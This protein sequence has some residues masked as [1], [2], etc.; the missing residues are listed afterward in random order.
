MPRG[1]LKKLS[2]CI[3]TIDHITISNVSLTAADFKEMKTAVESL[4][5]LTLTNNKLKEI[6]L[7]GFINL[8]TLLLPNNEL[9][10]ILGL[11]KCP[12]LTTLDLSHNK[13][14]SFSAIGGIEYFPE[15]CKVSIDKNPLPKLV[16]DALTSKGIVPVLKGI[17]QLVNALPPSSTR[18]KNKKKT[19]P[20]IETQPELVLNGH[21]HS[22]NGAIFSVDGGKVYTVSGHVCD[23]GQDYT[24]RIWDRATGAQ[25]R[26]FNDHQ[27]EVVRVAAH[28]DGK[29]VAT[30]GLDGNVFV[31][32]VN[33]GSKVETYQGTEGVCF[34]KNGEMLAVG[35]DKIRMYN[36]KRKQLQ[37]E[38]DVKGLWK[39]EFSQDGKQLACSCLDG[40]KIFD[41]STGELIQNIFLEPRADICFTSDGKNLIISS[42]HVFVFPVDDYSTWIRSEP[43]KETFTAVAEIPRKKEIAMGSFSGTIY[44]WKPNTGEIVNAFKGEPDEKR[45]RRIWQVSVAPDETQIITAERDKHAR[46]WNI[47]LVPLDWRP[48]YLFVDDHMAF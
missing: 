46:L 20:G 19:L 40:V 34:S 37:L 44:V 11:D 31:W 4:K 30:C 7:T 14:S 42:G 15:N 16:K 3:S 21:D 45:K 10:L 18:T 26:S 47:G 39:L 2:A 41:T 38:I 12:K 43:F 1:L 17:F 5:T 8:E 9:E 28:P 13:L 48:V 6:D 24:F 27:K 29:H 36:F 32:D 25:I 23:D 33:R 35:G 22:V